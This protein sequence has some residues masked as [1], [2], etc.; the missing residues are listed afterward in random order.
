M[1]KRMKHMLQACNQRRQ[2]WMNYLQTTDKKA[3]SIPR[4]KRERER[5]LIIVFKEFH[6][7]GIA[8]TGFRDITTDICSP[9][10]KYN[11]CNIACP[12]SCMFE[13]LSLATDSPGP[14]ALKA[15]R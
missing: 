9:P 15:L 4:E 3:D 11:V 7:L 5:D 2:S 12:V 1:T 13:V 8:A 14:R 6:S 10:E